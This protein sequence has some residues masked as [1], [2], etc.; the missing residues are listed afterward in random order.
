MRGVVA[1][2]MLLTGW[3]KAGYWGFVKEKA[4]V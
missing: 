3:L 4:I 2:I 1:P